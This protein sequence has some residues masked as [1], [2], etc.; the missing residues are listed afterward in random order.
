MDPNDETSSAFEVS[1]SRGE[2]TTVHLLGR[3]AA[4][5]GI[6]KVPKTKC[7]HK[8]RDQGIAETKELDIKVQEIP[9]QDISIRS[10]P[11]DH[12]KIL[13]VELSKDNFSHFDDLKDK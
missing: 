2:I 12:K 6:G 11:S 13:T 10:G 7:H 5:K 3:V 4:I 9:I 8:I 1:K